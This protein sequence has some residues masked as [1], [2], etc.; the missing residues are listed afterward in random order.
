MGSRLLVAGAELRA[1]LV[2]L[3]T[4]GL[5]YGPVP[6][7]LLAFFD[8]GVAWDGIRALPVSGMAAGPGPAARGRS[9]EC[10]WILD[11]GIRCGPRARPPE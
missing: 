9:G 3:F 10:P 1:P 8:A 5:D 6:A 7:E 2:G 11:H 4:G